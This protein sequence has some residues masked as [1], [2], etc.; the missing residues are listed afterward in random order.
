MRGGRKGEIPTQYIAQGRPQRDASWQN[1]TVGRYACC[2]CVHAKLKL[3][4][5]PC[6]NLVVGR[7][8]APA[9]ILVVQDLDLESYYALRANK[10][11][12]QRKGSFHVR[13]AKD[14]ELSGNSIVDTASQGFG[15][16]KALAR[17]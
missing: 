2:E 15:L 11:F 9:N 3:L 4:M 10:A 5:R 1:N 12:R 6:C 17:S 13:L 14:F 16:G 7:T 8:E